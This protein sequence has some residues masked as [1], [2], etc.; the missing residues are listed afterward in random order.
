MSVMDPVVAPPTREDHEVEIRSPGRARWWGPA[1]WALALVVGVWLVVAGREQLVEAGG[2]LVHA[3]L[4]LLGLGALAQAGALLA[5]GQLYRSVLRGV[6][7]RVS[8]RTVTG[9]AVRVYA[10]SRLL[11]GGGAAAALFAGQRLRRLGVRDGHALTAVA[12]AGLT[13]MATLAGLVAT[14]GAVTSGA[15]WLIGAATIAPTAALLGLAAALRTSRLRTRLRHGAGRKSQ[16]RWVA[17][18]RDALATLAERPPRARHVLAGVAWSTTAWVAELTALW[19]GMAAVGAAVAPHHAALGLGAA[20]AVTAVPH[21]PGGIGVVE[22][23]MS[24]TFTGLGLPGPTAIAGVLAY[25][26]VAFWFPVLTGAALLLADGLL[27][28]RTAP[29]AHAPEERS[30][31]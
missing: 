23:A 5:L 25:R 19:L 12:L 3:D 2:A 28:R 21:T 17:P 18:F 30:E 16:R 13:T 11:P 6:H 4:L 1:L 10:L 8:S 29:T 24:A 27:D 22:A 26:I 7:E 31:P 14:A 9:V 15:P 20:N